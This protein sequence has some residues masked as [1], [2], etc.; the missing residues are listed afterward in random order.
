MGDELLVTAEGAVRIVTLNRPDSLNIID[1]TLHRRL[2]DVWQELDLDPGARCVVLTGAGRAFSGGGDFAFLKA[3]HLSVDLRYAISHEA[4]AIL[5]AMLNFRLPVVAAVN[6]PAVGLGASLVL[7]CDL[8]LMAERSYL[9][10]P[11]VSIGL[12]A[13]DGGALLWPHMMSLIRAK[14]YIYTGE[15]IPAGVAVELGLANR[16]VPAEALMEEALALADKLARQPARALQTTKRAFAKHVAQS[17]LAIIDYGLAA[18]TVELG[19]EEH[20]G[21]IREFLGTDEYDA[22]VVD[23]SGDGAVD[24]VVDR[25]DGSG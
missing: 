16:T 13:G 4:G 1:A 23:S 20:I 11:H 9:C 12:T 25:G 15:R 8:V 19:A 21:K 2:L 6:G 7:S 14:E 22:I 3:Q 17:A 18:E 10:D 5:N 24:S